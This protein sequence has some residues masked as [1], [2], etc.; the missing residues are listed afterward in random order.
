MVKR[1][2]RRLMARL[3]KWF[4]NA[5]PRIVFLHEAR[6]EA[7]DAKAL[8]QFLNSEL[9]KRMINMLNVD[10]CAAQSWAICPNQLDIQFRSGFA[11]GKQRMIARLF[12]LAMVNDAVQE[13]EAYT[14]KEIQEQ[15]DAMARGETREIVYGAD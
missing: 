5:E 8:E 9:G 4:G 10:A 14:E 11:H 1:F 15:L 7:D 2:I 12:E 6:W 3:S 13:N